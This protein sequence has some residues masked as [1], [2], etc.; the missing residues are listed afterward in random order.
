ME[1]EAP[2]AVDQAI[3]SRTGNGA[4]AGLGT[5][6]PD[7]W[8]RQRG[9]PRT[10][11]YLAL[12][13]YKFNVP[14]TENFL[15]GS[16]CPTCSN[17]DLNPTNTWTPKALAELVEGLGGA[18]V[19]THS[20]SG[21]IG[22]HM[23]R[24]LKE[25]GKLGLLKGLITIEGAC[26]LP[27]AGLVASDF[28]NIPYLVLIGEHDDDRI[29]P[30]PGDRTVCQQT[31]DAIKAA[32]GNSDY[33]KLDQPGFWQGKYSGPY[34]TGLCRSLRRRLAHDD[35][36]EQPGALQQGRKGRNIQVMDVM[37]E[38]TKKNI[39]APK[40]TSCNWDD[41]HH[42]HDDDDDHGHGHR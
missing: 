13:A 1:P 14:N 36:R 15:P 29:Y 19:A 28:K 23:T 41:D 18:V 10:D 9:L 33:I 25:H 31:V 34:G 32:G 38:W 26:S 6:I 35:D 8:P 11:R 24:I 37:L 27:G 30:A 22:H 7:Q 5:I 21:D 3:A 39:K 2:W 4:P 12:D 17:P 20:Q 42:D 16:T 40:T